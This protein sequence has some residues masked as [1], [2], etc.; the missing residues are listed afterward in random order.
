MKTGEKITQSVISTSELSGGISGNSVAVVRYKDGTQ[1]VR[2][3]SPYGSPTDMRGLDERSTWVLDEAFFYGAEMPLF[4]HA[5]RIELPNGTSYLEMP[6]HTGYTCD[7]SIKNGN[8]EEVLVQRRD[9]L[10][11]LK[12]KGYF[13]GSQRLTGTNECWQKYILD[14]SNLWRQIADPATCSQ[15]LA[16]WPERAV[17]PRLALCESLETLIS[18]HAIP[19]G[20][21][22]WDLHFGNIMVDPTTKHITAID[23]THWYGDPVIVPLKLSF[24]MRATAS[25]Q[26]LPETVL[27]HLLSMY[28]TD[29]EVAQMVAENFPDDNDFMKRFQAAS[30]LRILKKI[31]ALS[32]E[33]EVR[34]FQIHILSECLDRVYSS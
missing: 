6:F 34:S 33:P 29:R 31:S 25:P 22:P 15:L 28:A 2:K 11:L 3:S 18:T 10:E 27:T 1:V 17:N 26:N 4:I 16:D 21:Y 7:E 23:Q 19:N 30:A 32:S 14:H 12:R 5:Q 13:Y 20:F 9:L 24:L 8:I